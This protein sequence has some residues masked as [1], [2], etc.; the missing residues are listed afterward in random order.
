MAASRV[1]LED[2]LAL[3]DEIAGLVRAGLPL[4]LG[5]RQASSSTL[6]GLSVLSQRIAERVAIGASLEQALKDEGDHIPAIYL[7]VVEAGLRSGRLAEAL[8]LVSALG[9]SLLEL[10]RRVVLA[11]IYPLLVFCC[12]YALFLAIV[13]GFVPV[14]VSTYEM[15]RVEP[16]FLT[17]CLRS[18]WLHVATWGPAVPVLLLVAWLIA[19]QMG[20]MYA[21]GSLGRLMSGRVHQFAWLPWM[22]PIIR[23]FDYAAFVQ[24]LRLLLQ[25]A[26]P[27]PEALLLA[28]HA[29]G[30]AQISQA[31]RRVATGVRE[32][33]PLATVLHHEH[34]LPT[35]LRSMLVMGERHQSLDSTLAQTGEIYQRRAERY[36]H[37]S[38]VV[39]PVV[40]TC[41]I[42]GTLTMFYGL[43]LL[44][45]L[46]ELFDQ[47]A[48]P[49]VERP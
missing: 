2:L 45:P 49:V 37:L 35:F 11:M 43:A 12:G 21:S 8:E 47:L 24:L 18:L 29:T 13:V 6:G 4:D 44:G 28:G 15:L 27:L 3:N 32:G 34:R 36:V 10:H 22:P 31:M 39:L 23:N 16:S 25:H 5:L 17:R 7:A 41:L 33:Q 20:Q 46:R 48:S 9:R 1:K 38:R 14:L 26:T 19:G 30:N 40:L 42:G